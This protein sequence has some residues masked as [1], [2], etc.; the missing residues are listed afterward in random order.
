[1]AASNGSSDWQPPELHVSPPTWYQL[2]LQNMTATILLATVVVIIVTRIASSSNTK[3]RHQNG[4]LTV[5]AH[6]YWLPLLGHIPQMGLDGESFLNGLRSIYRN[7]AFALNFG[8]S[9]HNIVYTPGHVTALINAKKENADAETVAKKLMINLFCFPKN[10]FDK[11]DAAYK[12]LVECYREILTNPGLEH[13]MNNTARRAQDNINNLVSY[14]E[15]PVDQMPWEKKANTVLLVDEADG[16]SAPP[17]VVEA[18][19]FPLLRDFVA[20]TAVPSI[21]GTDFLANYPEFIQDVW[22][23]DMGFLMMAASLPRWL[24]IPALTRAHIARKACVEKLDT[25]HENLEKYFEGQPLESKWSS[26]DDISTL[27]RAR[28]EVYRK[29]N[30]SIRARTAIDWALMWAANANSNSFVFWMINRIYDDRVLLAQ[31][32]EEI[33]PYVTITQERTGLPIEPSPQI[34]K[35]D[36]DRLCDSCPLLKSVYVETLRLDTAPW[37]FKAVNQDFILQS[38]EKGAEPLLLRKGEYVH[39]AHDL[40]NTDPNYWNDPMTFKPDRHIKKDSDGKS[41]AD[42][43]SIRPYGGGASMCKGRAFALKEAMTFTATIISLWEIEPKGGGKWKMP[44]H[45]KATGTYTTTEDTRVWISR[46]K[47]DL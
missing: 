12:E 16:K 13:M 23:F 19:L 4:A 32:R 3:S 30:F 11:Y 2:P 41:T 17:S 9:R 29:H 33:A 22:T 31:L 43:G 34:T 44:K 24:P 47:L 39:A 10:E 20:W 7:G 28:T 8:G 27:I 18:S 5:P 42:L 21:V 26:L 14:L 45:K 46:R 15:S 36:V 6:P 35:I 37:S 38:R 40:H 1:M 25:F